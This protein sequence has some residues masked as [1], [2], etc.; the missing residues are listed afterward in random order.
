MLTLDFFIPPHPIAKTG[1]CLCLGNPVFLKSKEQQ[2][3]IKVYKFFPV[4]RGPLS[5]QVPIQHQTWIPLGWVSLAFPTQ[6]ISRYMLNK[7]NDPD[8]FRAD[9]L[10]STC[11]NTPGIHQ[12]QGEISLLYSMQTSKQENTPEAPLISDTLFQGLF[13]K[14]FLNR[15]CK[16]AEQLRLMALVLSQICIAQSQFCASGKLFLH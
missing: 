12:N 15:S 8:N 11:S 7:L 16:Y 10:F 6:P 4:G 1:C 14:T 3:W 13:L 5:A 9:V 2:C